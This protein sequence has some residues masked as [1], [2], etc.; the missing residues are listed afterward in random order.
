MVPV[1]EGAYASFPTDGR[2]YC[3]SSTPILVIL[4]VFTSRSTASCPTLPM[5][6]AG[7]RVQAH[8]ARGRGAAS[9]PV[10]SSCPPYHYWSSRSDQAKQGC[11]CNRM[12]GSKAY[13][14]Q[15]G[16][17]P[18]GRTTAVLDAA[19]ELDHRVWNSRTLLSSANEGVVGGPGSDSISS[20]SRVSKFKTESKGYDQCK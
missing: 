17:S 9:D 19:E 11:A 15:R 7:C 3:D 4:S 18:V 20:R 16:A 13:H 6:T 8:W 14:K 10:V 2:T 5:L 12:Q 1:P